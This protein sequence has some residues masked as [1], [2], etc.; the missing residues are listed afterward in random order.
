LAAGREVYASDDVCLH[1]EHC[2]E[3]GA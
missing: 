2:G 1:I 3:A